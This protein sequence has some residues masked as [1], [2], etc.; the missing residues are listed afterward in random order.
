MLFWSPG[1][2]NDPRHPGDDKKA[3]T[4]IDQCLGLPLLAYPTRKLE[5]LIGGLSNCQ[6]MFC[7]DGGAMHIG[8]A[9]GLP[10][11]CLFGDSNAS[12]WY[13]WGV[14]HQVLQPESRNVCD[15]SVDEAYAA[16]RRT[17]IG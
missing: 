9:L 7:S 12:N 1:D 3:T 16:C 17:L 10:I 4:I 5:E 2:E 13:P 15:V 8:A 11:V 6:A 14:Q